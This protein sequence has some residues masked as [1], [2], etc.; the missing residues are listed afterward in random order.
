MKQPPTGIMVFAA[1]HSF[2]V[3]IFIVHAIISIPFILVTL[4]DESGLGA[5]ALY[6]IF[7]TW[8]LLSISGTIVAGL[9]YRQEWS[10]TFVMAL[11]GI[12]LVFGVIGIISGNMFPVF[13]VIINGVII[14]Y[15]RKPHI[16]EWFSQP[17]SEL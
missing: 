7:W 6:D 11:A 14:L 3:F 9:L 8:I 5:L 4:F 10:R 17:I 2:A 16:K 12:G 1:L 13:T 15:M